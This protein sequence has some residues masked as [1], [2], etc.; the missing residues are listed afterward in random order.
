MVKRQLLPINLIFHLT[1]AHYGTKSGL[2]LHSIS[3]LTNTN[4]YEKILYFLGT[5]SLWIKDN[6]YNL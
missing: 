5:C 3:K 4:S 6:T 1:M 2:D